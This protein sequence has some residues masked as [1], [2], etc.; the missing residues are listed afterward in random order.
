MKWLVGYDGWGG[1]LYATKFILTNDP[2]M[3]KDKEIYIYPY[4]YTYRLILYKLIKE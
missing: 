4:T 3:C 2:D 1:R